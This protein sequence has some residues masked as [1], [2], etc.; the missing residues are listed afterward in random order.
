MT[1]GAR[2]L[3]SRLRRS[4]WN[5]LGTVVRVDAS[6]PLVALTFDDGPDPEYTPRLLDVL[7]RS[8]A[9]ATF[10]MIGEA[11]RRHP[12]LVDDVA[13]RGHCVGNHTDTH[14]SLPTLSGRDRRRQIRRCAETLAPHADR[15]LRPPK[16]HQTVGSRLDALWCRHRPVAWS[17]SVDDWTAHDPDWLTSRLAEQLAPGQIVLLHDGLWDPESE[18]AADRGP[19]V[20]A[21]R[22][23]LDRFRDRYR[24]VTVPELLASGSEVRTSWFNSPPDGE[25]A[26]R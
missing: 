10:F 23:I 20:E 19:T 13:A 24:F 25:P 14:P 22:R 2:K 15:L 17:V 26:E 21:V 4:R 5:P 1:G 6:A 7:E 3:A 18:A 11:A 8:G 16:G 12:D 9:R